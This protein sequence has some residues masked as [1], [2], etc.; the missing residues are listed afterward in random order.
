MPAEE[1][2]SFVRGQL[3]LSMSH[4]D[5]WQAQCHGTEA[6]QVATVFAYTH[7]ARLL[8]CAVILSTQALLLLNP[9]AVSTS[10]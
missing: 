3:M 2:T 7:V 9:A 5:G 6:C 10:K 4:K 1:L 8:A